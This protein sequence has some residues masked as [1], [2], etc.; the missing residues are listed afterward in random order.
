MS[1]WKKLTSNAVEKNVDERILDSALESLGLGLDKTVK[2][3]RN[4]F[5]HDNCYAA[6]TKDGNVTS[7]GIDFTENHGLQLVGDPWGTGLAGDG[8]HQEILDKISQAYQVEHIKA[9]A[10]EN[11][12][13]IE[14]LTTNADGEIELELSS[15]F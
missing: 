9:K 1:V 14:S 4:S 13:T 10:L 8:G 2:T 6:I 7:V 5:G 12:W 11:M 15:M 3:I